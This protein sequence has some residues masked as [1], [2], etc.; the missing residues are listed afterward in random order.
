MSADEIRK[1][2]CPGRVCFTK[3]GTLVTRTPPSLQIPREINYESF[4]INNNE[5]W[6]GQ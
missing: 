4:F 3:D 6:S 1:T 5:I 2:G